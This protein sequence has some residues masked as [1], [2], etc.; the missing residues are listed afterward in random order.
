MHWTC[1]KQRNWLTSAG[2]KVWK[3]ETLLMVLHVFTAWSS[4]SVFFWRAIGPGFSIYSGWLC[5]SKKSSIWT[6]QLS[7]IEGTIGPICRN[8][9]GVLFFHLRSLTKGNIFLRGTDMHCKLSCDRNVNSALIC[10][11][12]KMCLHAS[13][14]FSQYDSVLATPKN[15]AW[16]PDVCL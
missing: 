8:S 9:G 1:K 6:F 12:S 14:E 3:C 5:Q 10:R 4:Y 13:S 16:A 2:L 11:P 15:S 7:G